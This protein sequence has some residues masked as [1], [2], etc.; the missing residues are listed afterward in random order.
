MTDSTGAGGESK[1]DPSKSGAAHSTGE[2][3]GDSSPGDGYVK[4]SQMIA[5]LNSAT[6]KTD[7]AMAKAEALERELAEMKA[8]KAPKP[9][10]RE[11]LRQLVESGNLTQD[12][13]DAVYE[14]HL[15]EK[16]KREAVAEV[17]QTTSAQER[18]RKVA[19]DLQGYKDLV[20]EV[21]VDGSEERVKVGKE[22]DY[23]VSLGYPKT[24]ETEA[25]ALRA[26]YGSLEILRASKTARTG[27]A[28]THAETGGGDRPTEGTKDGPPKGLT[29][30]QRDY[31]DKGIKQGRYAD[32]KAVTEELK[33]AKSGARAR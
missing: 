31:Y 18:A 14:K 16:V 7:A 25:A 20:P 3:Q 28:D 27:P 8:A 12:A 26:A 13:A 15:I 22:F 10:T 21:W 29:A 9:P 33:F 19:A 5:A 4:K 32:W 24:P 30:A 2:S 17:G 6:A 11:E 23:L 1:D